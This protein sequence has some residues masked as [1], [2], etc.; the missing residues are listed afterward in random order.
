MKPFSFLLF[1]SILSI[2][3]MQVTGM[4]LSNIKADTF[5]NVAY[6]NNALQNMDVYLPATRSAQQTP[7]LI[8]LHGGGWNS[9]SRHSLS[10]YVDSFKTRLPNYAIFNVDYRLVSSKIKFSDQETD[11]KNAVDF[12]VAHSNDYNINGSK[13][14]MIGVSAGAHLAMLQAYKNTSPKMAA[15]IDFFGPADLV[16]MYQKPWNEMIPHLMESIIGGT[17]QTNQAYHDLSPVSFI[18]AASPPTLIFHGKQDYIVDVSQ[19][20]ILKQKLQDAGVINELIV[21]PNAG[22]GW[23]GNTLS[24]SF[25]KIEVFLQRYF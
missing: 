17:P 4:T 10:A 1:M 18:N 20:Q 3:N 11:I 23:F 19:S 8:L 24:N 5:L 21:Y 25:D 9:G 14:V 13:L 7:S 22:H 12:I 2:T 15:V 6:G 16:A